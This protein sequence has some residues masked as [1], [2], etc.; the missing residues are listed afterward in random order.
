MAEIIQMYHI[1]ST[2][3]IV[4]YKRERPP[5]FIGARRMGKTQETTNKKDGEYG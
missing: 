1:I 3:Y 5:Y 4:V 2:D